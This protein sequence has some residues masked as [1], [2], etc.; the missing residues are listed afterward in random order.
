ME[1]VQEDFE[2]SGI[3]GKTGNKIIGFAVVPSMERDYVKIRSI[4]G[5]FEIFPCYG[6]VLIIFLVSIVP[7]SAYTTSIY[8]FNSAD[9]VSLLKKRRRSYILIHSQV[10]FVSENVKFASHIAKKQGGG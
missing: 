9:S 1:E 4:E 7:L 6:S 5:I 2:K 8:D 3:E 10:N